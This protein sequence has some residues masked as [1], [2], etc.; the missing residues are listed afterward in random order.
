MT[1][2]LQCLVSACREE[3]GTLA[4]VVNNRARG[5]ALGSWED[6]PPAAYCRS[7]VDHARRQAVSLLLRGRNEER[8]STRS[9][10]DA[11]SSAALL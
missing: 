7:S 1:L 11:S 4:G 6:R 8:C 10:R 2:S 5:P 3:R 9:H